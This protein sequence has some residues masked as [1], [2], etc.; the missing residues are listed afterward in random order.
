M[1]ATLLLMISTVGVLAWCFWRLN[2]TRAAG[3]WWLKL[4]VLATF[5][6]A[7]WLLLALIGAGDVTKA[8]ALLLASLCGYLAWGVVRDLQLR[9]EQS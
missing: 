9:G 5:A 7:S 2:R 1:L 4:S 8:T 3:H 6:S